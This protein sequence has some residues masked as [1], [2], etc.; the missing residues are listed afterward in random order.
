MLQSPKIL[1]I[2]C[3]TQ[4]KKSL[5]VCEKSTDKIWND[6]AVVYEEI[7]KAHTGYRVYQKMSYCSWYFHLLQNISFCIAQVF[8]CSFIH[9]TVLQIVEIS[10][11]QLEQYCTKCEFLA[12][13]KDELKRHILL[14]HEG[15]KFPCS[16]CSAEYASAAGLQWHVRNKHQD[17]V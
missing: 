10:C 4:W 14:K 5:C 12:T 6:K 17:I 7:M 15:V 2:I 9:I 13:R 11:G 8:S 3:L 1:N 16:I